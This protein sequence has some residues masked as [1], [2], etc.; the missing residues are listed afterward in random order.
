MRKLV[1][2]SLLLAG[3][4]ACKNFSSP[5]APAIKF[6]TA[7]PLEAPLTIK[8]LDGN[9]I[10]KLNPNVSETLVF[11]PETEQRTI[12][13]VDIP[14]R[15]FKAPV[16]LG[17]EDVIN[18]EINDKYT[19]GYH[20]KG[21][22]ETEN[23]AI[24]NRMLNK[25]DVRMRQLMKQIYESTNKGDY[26]ELRKHALTAMQQN[27]DTLQKTGLKLIRKDYGALANVLML[28][29]VFGDEKLFPITDFPGIYDSVINGLQSRYPDNATAIQFIDKTSKKLRQITE[30]KEKAKATS[31]GYTAPD[32]QLPS[33]QQQMVSLH[34]QEAEKK[35]LVFW[36]L[37]DKKTSEIIHNLENLLS[38]NV[39]QTIVYAISLNPNQKRWEKMVSNSR[40]I[41]VN[42]PNGLK[43]SS[44]R[45]YGVSSTPLFVL[46]NQQHKILLRT[47]DFMEI[48][49]HIN[50]Q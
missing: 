3:L 15:T 41:H 26:A 12:Y 28:Q 2:I 10:K 31:E 48:E 49:N 9:E 43:A 38:D 17:E 18:L 27:R 1:V 8:D 42:E 35:L 29:Q 22:Q 16:S 14:G 46:M 21:S 25:S 11:S 36:D 23:L 6:T 24:L 50:K 32:I 45:L 19:T 20:V 44:A 33:T 39:H 7:Q 34:Q 37:D 30:R 40:G 13:L 4:S 5:D 47:N